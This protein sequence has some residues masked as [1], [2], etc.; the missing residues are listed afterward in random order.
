VPAGREEPAGKDLPA[1]TWTK[2]LT[3]KEKQVKLNESPPKKESPAGL[4]D[5][6]EER[7]VQGFS[8]LRLARDDQPAADHRCHCDGAGVA[9]GVTDEQLI[10]SPLSPSICKRHRFTLLSLEYRPKPHS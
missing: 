6:A 4:R 5:W 9:A 1:E 8:S 7:A 3:S 10:S 2:A